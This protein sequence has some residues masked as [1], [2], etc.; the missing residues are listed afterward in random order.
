MWEVTFNFQWPQERYYIYTVMYN[1]IARLLCLQT[2]IALL[3]ACFSVPEKSLCIVQ[4]F[5][6]MDSFGVQI[7]NEYDCPLLTLTNLFRCISSTAISHSVSVV[8]EC[9]TTCTF[10]HTQTTT[11]MERTYVPS[12]KLKFVH[13]MSNSMYALNVY[14]MHSYH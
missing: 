10:S 6:R 12:Q 14:C 9:S 8:H 7:C 3:T 2:D 1:S 5:E 13:D 4:L 11:I